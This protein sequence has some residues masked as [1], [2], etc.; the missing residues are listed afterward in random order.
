MIHLFIQWSIINYQKI[1]FSGKKMELVEILMSE[2][3]KTEKD[4]F[5]VNLVYVDISC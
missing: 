5:C 2:V 1:K 3:T 4:I